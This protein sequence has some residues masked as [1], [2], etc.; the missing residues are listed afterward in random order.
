MSPPFA[1]G[2]G[3]YLARDSRNDLGSDRQGDFTRLPRSEGL[4]S[5]EALSGL[6]PDGGPLALAY[7]VPWMH[8][9]Y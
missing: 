6:E 4:S 8:F 3:A 1:S 9:L 2:L 7:G 5:K